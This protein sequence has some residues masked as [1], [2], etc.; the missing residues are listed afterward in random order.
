M[1]GATGCTTCRSEKPPALAS[2]RKAAVGTV[3]SAVTA[4]AAA[5]AGGGGDGGSRVFKPASR[6][7]GDLYDAPNLAFWKLS[8]LSCGLS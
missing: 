5:A 4:A 7:M 3:S 8:E 6:L 1:G 2:C